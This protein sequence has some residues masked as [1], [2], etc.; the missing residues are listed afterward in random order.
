MFVSAVPVCGRYLSVLRLMRF[1]DI[2]FY[3]KD[4]MCLYIPFNI[5]CRLVDVLCI[6]V[7]VCDVCMSNK[8]NNCVCFKYIVCVVVLMAAAS[9]DLIM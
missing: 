8:Y 2:F 1:N 6:L 7:D 5:L 9:G 4:Y 3:N